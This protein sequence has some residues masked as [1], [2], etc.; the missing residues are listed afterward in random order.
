MSNSIRLPLPRNKR[1]THTWFIGGDW[2]DIH[3]DLAAVDI[4]LQRAKALPKKERRLIINGDFLDFPETREVNVKKDRN[5]ERNIETIYLP[6][7]NEAFRWGN[8]MLDLLQNTFETIVFIEGNHDWRA[9]MFQ[10]N[11][12]PEI[13]KPFF[14]LK[15]QLRLSKRGIKFVKYNDWCDLGKLAITHGMYHGTTAVKKHVEAAG[16]STLFSH[17]HQVE[18]KSFTRRGDTLI[19]ASLPAMCTLN[20]EYMRNRANNW[21]TGFGEISVKHNG[22]FNLVIHTIWDGELASLGKILKGRPNEIENRLS[23]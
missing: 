12:A 13:Y 4:L 23:L 5:L 11:Y 3:C 20:P 17:V 8:S 7:A 22:N 14:D 18:M 1:E 6:E 15:K 21:T 9:Q 19:A 16:T 2:H 10:D